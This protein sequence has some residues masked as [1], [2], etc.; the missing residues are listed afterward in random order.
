MCLLKK[1]E[2]RIENWKFRWLSLGGRLTLANSVLHSILVYWLSLVKLP[3]IVLRRIQN[4]ISKFISKGG[5]KGS[6][7]HLT[8]W[9]NI[10]RPKHFGGWGIKQ[11]SWFAQSLDAKSCWRRLFGSG[12]WNSV[13]CKKY[14][15]GIDLISWLRR[16][17]HNTQGTSVIWKNFMDSLPI[18]KR[19]LAWEIGSRIRIVLGRNPFIGCNS[20]YK[21]SISLLQVLN[22][23]NIFSLAQAVDP[24]DT[25]TTQN[26][27]ESI[28][29]G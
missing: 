6:G 7:F 11:I 24:V 8:K 14:F 27:L 13:L 10:A 25:G 3:T 12:L 18:I 20:K 15:Q 26:W 4:L 28:Q 19:C 9:K 23:S 17:T 22:N 2:K 21:I 5:K 16:D 29:I 1:I